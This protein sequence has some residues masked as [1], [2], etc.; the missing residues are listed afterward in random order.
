VTEVSDGLYLWLHQRN[1]PDPP[2]LHRVDLQRVRGRLAELG[3]ADPADM[4]PYLAGL[5][6]TLWWVRQWFRFTEALPGEIEGRPV[7]LVEGRWPPGTLAFLLPERAELDR[8]PEGIQPEDLPDGVPW[9][10]RLAVGRSDLLPRRLELLAIPGPRPVAAGP[11][12]VITA[13]EFVEVELDGPVDPTAFFYQPANEGLIDLT[14]AM[15]KSL[16]S[17]RP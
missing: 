8:R 4:A 6:R 13:I 10:V 2:V 11:V 5:Q 12:E 9:A 3:V 14:D 16:G 1:G 17:L 7:W 15:V